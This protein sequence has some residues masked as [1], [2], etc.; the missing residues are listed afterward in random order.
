M[1][2]AHSLRES[3]PPLRSL[4]FAPFRPRPYLRALYM[5]LAFPLGIA[6]FV[7]LTVGVTLGVSTVIVLVGAPV[8]L[9]V[10]VLVRGLGWLERRLVAALLGVDLP[11]SE[12]PFLEGS[13]RARV[14]G[15]VFDRS[16]WTELCYLASMFGLGMGSFVFLVT[17]LATSLAFVATPLYY[18]S[19]P[20]RVG[21]FPGDPIQLTQSLYVPWDDLLVG[22]EVGFTV[23]EWAVDS[24]PDALAMSL[25]G[26]GLLWVTLVLIDGLGW[27]WGQYAR[28]LLAADVR[29]VASLRRR[30]SRS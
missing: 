17:A 15:L 2:A 25:V 9:A 22:A 1:F 13:I 29:P 12:Y 26:V 27:L 14:A 30:V 5:V 8:L 28:L 4:L 3:R 20:G 24:L 10:L 6:Y 16:T 11:D 19:A 7:V 21:I 23:S 18:D